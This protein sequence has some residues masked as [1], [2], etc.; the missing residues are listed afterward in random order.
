MEIRII[1]GDTLDLRFCR[2][3]KNGVIKEKPDNLIFAVKKGAQKKEYLFQKRLDDGITYNE[4]NNYYYFTIE[5]KDTE[6][7][8]IG[9]CVFNI[10]VIMGS[11]V[12]TI[13]AGKFIITDEVAYMESVV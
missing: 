5:S 9:T 3:D 4:E 11:K 2:K 6:N 8:K 1:R 7:L 13:C 10:K 12:K